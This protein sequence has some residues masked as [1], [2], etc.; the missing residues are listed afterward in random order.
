MPKCYECEALG[1]CGGGCPANAKIVDGSIWEVDRRFCVHSKMTLE[2]LIWDQY[3]Q[4]QKSS[5]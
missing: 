5:I 4:M 1:I 3:S 2:W